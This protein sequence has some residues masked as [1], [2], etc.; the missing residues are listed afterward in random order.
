MIRHL[1]PCARGRV[2]LNLECAPDTRPRKEEHE[3]KGIFCGK[4]TQR[5]INWTQEPSGAHLSSKHQIGGKLVL[6]RNSCAFGLR[7]LCFSRR[8]SLA[9][10][11]YETTTC[12]LAPRKTCM[13]LTYLTIHPTYGSIAVRRIH[14]R[15]RLG[16]QLKA[17][18]L[19]FHAQ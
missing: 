14:S 4:P 8:P 16:A 2:V 13:H 3:N 6:Y 9:M 17:L 7:Y 5:L 11:D 15:E 12:P 1:P 19:R 18:F 10:R